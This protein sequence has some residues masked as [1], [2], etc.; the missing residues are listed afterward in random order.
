[1]ERPCTRS[2]ARIKRFSRGNQGHLKLFRALAATK[3]QMPT[4]GVRA[5]RMNRG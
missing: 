2:K 1:M 5:G 4:V 3:R